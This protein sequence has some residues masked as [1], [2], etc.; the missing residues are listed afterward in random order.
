MNWDH[1]GPSEMTRKA[2][3]P[4]PKQVA[5]TRGLVVEDAAT[6]FTG[7]VVRVEKSGGVHLVVLEGRKGVTRAFPLGLGF[8][9][10]GAAVNLVVPTEQRAS[11]PART[12]SGS[13]V[14]APRRAAVA[15]ASRIWVEGIHDAELVEKIWGD[16]LRVEGIVVEPLHGIDDLAGAVQQ[17][18]PGPR[19][20]LAVLLDHLVDGSKEQRIAA[21]TM[22]SDGAQ[23]NVLIVGHPYVDIWQAVKPEVIGIRAWPKI[24]RNEDWKTG[25]LARL[26]LPHQTAADIGLGWKKILSRVNSFKDLEPDLLGRVEHMIDFVTVHD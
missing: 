11:R 17:F 10:D 4:T 19:R 12:A 9:I 14:V 6:G 21:E 5:A 20:R 18:Q 1:W 24:P 26:G 15:K 7:A 16:D 22:K 25:M 2:Q 13:R 3:R 8:M 23:D